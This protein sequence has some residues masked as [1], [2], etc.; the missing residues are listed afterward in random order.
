MIQAGVGQYQH[1]RNDN[2]HRGQNQNR[3]RGKYG[4]SNQAQL[5][6]GDDI[7]EADRNNLPHDQV[8]PVQLTEHG[9]LRIQKQGVQQHCIHTHQHIF[10]FIGEVFQIIA[11]FPGDIICKRQDDHFQKRFRN[12][13][14]A[15][16]ILIGAATQFSHCL[17]A[18]PF[19]VNEQEVKRASIA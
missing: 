4:I 2:V 15:L 12:P 14:K 6:I 10:S 17:S 9:A 1:N 5:A 19:P 13:D 16:H 7:D 8:N 18:H 3:R 11:F